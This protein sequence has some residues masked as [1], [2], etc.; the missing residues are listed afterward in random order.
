MLQAARAACDWSMVELVEQRI[1]AWDFSQA[2]KADGWYLRQEIIWNKNNPMPESARDRCTK[3]HEHIFL[4]SKSAKYYFDSRAIAEPSTGNAHDRARKD[5]VSPGHKRTPGADA[6]INGM[7]ACATSASP[8]PAPVPSGWDT[9][10]G[11]HRDRAG[12]YRGN[13][14]G[15]GHGYDAIPKPRAGVNP[16]A[17]LATQ[18]AAAAY[19]DGKS[20]R[21]GRGAGFRSKQNESFSS[22]LVGTVETRNKRTVWTFPTQGFK[23]S[24]YATFPEALVEPCVLAG[25]PI[26]GTVLDCFGGSGTTGVVADRHHRDAILIDLDD[27][28][29]PMAVDRITAL[30]PLF[31]EVTT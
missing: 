15:F 16:K 8:D 10:H 9:G 7:R 21:L 5:R 25:C 31:A 28:N 17:A 30:A 27:R 24:H 4:L 1:R 12:R 23:G 18:S 11:S 3:G 29:R 14:V 19:T 22:H 20:D 6:R 13:G 26:G 2:L